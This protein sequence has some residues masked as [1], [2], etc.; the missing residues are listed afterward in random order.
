M[1]NWRLVTKL[2]AKSE[3]ALSFNK[4]GSS[5]APTTALKKT[6]LESKLNNSLGH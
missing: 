4:V 1:K 6:K 2:K 5:N 3:L